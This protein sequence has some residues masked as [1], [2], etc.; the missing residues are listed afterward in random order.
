MGAGSSHCLPEIPP[1]EVFQVFLLQTVILGNCLIDL[2]LPKL[3]RPRRSKSPMLEIPV[4]STQFCSQCSLYHHHRWTPCFPNASPTRIW[5]QATSRNCNVSCLSSLS[6]AFGAQLVWVWIWLQIYELSAEG[7]VGSTWARPTS[8]RTPASFSR[9][10][11][12]HWEG[13]WHFLPN[14]SM[15]SCLLF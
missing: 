7:V 6:A 3:C 5:T 4:I 14:L 1:D 13:R 10:S 11:S 12:S 15:L 8:S 2:L 9:S